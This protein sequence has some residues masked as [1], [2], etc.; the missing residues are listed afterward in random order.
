DRRCLHEPRGV[1][2]WSLSRA[3]VRRLYL[4]E[5]PRV[6]DRAAAWDAP[7]DGALVVARPSGRVVE[8]GGLQRRVD[9]RPDRDARPARGRARLGKEAEGRARLRGRVLR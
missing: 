1:A 2:G 3:L 4:P 9:L 8:P 7:G 5:L 6:G